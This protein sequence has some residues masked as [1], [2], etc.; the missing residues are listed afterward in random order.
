MQDTSSTAQQIRYLRISLLQISNQISAHL[1]SGG[2]LS[3]HLFGPHL[4]N[5]LLFPPRPNIKEPFSSLFS[6][7]SLRL[8]HTLVR[9]TVLGVF[10]G[11]CKPNT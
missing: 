10:H 3:G 6:S 11:P 2:T 5:L 4:Q 7:L 1:I 8:S 9:A